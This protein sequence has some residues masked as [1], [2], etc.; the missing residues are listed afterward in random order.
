[1]HVILRCNAWPV[2]QAHRRF[3]VWI[4]RRNQRFGHASNEKTVSTSTA[5]RYAGMR[6]MARNNGKIDLLAFDVHPSRP[7]LIPAYEL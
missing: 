7:C 5:P 4:C 2:A 1:M 3:R 6:L